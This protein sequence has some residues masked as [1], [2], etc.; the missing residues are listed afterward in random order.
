MDI[1]WPL[2]LFS[3]FAGCG[4]ALMV[5]AAVAECLGVGKKS[6][7]I[8]SVAALVLM[9]VGGCAS[10]LHLAHPQAVMAAVTNIFSFSGISVE[11]IM[12]GVTFVLTLVYAVMTVRAENSSALKV[13]G[14]LAGLSGLVLAFVCGNGYRMSTMEHW[15]TVLLPFAYLG[16][17]WVSG[18]LAY[19]ALASAREDVSGMSVYGI[20]VSLVNL[21]ALVA[22]GASCGFGGAH[23]M[24]YVAGGIVVGGIAPLVCSV[25]WKKKPNPALLVA[26][27]GAAVIGALCLRAVMWLLGTGY[28]DF[29]TAAASR[30]PF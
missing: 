14:V 9:V 15:N 21:V 27:A 19:M 3:L 2:V 16:S 29:F 6:R 7:M 22:Y 10:L 30:V 12:L 23:A 17:A 11:L 25:L 26:G 1:Q 28:L 13:I 18:A 4:G 24:L 20:G 8:A 5:S